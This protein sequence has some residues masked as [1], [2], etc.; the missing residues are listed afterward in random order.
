MYGNHGLQNDFHHPK[1]KL[2][3]HLQ[4]C[5]LLCFPQLLGPTNLFFTYG[6]AYFGQ[7]IETE[8]CNF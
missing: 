1:K 2:H 3:V 8:S 5:P 7:F 6:F 4:L